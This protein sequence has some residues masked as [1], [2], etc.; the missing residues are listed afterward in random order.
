[1]R[2]KLKSL[3]HRFYPEKIFHAPEWIVLGVNNICNLHCKMCDVGLKINDTNFAVNLTG[4]KPINMP[5]ELIKRLIDQ[6]YQYYPK[7]KLGYAF[8]E[9]LIYPHLMESLTYANDKKLFTSITTNALN[10][11]HKA[12]DLVKAGLNDLYIS[13]DGPEEIHNYIRGHKNSFNRAVEGIEALSEY[14]N[15]PKISVFCVITEWNIGHLREFVESI[16][17]LP[18]TQVGF[19][20]TNFTTNSMADAH[21]ELLMGDYPATYSNTDEID[22]DKMN[23]DILFDEI[24]VL[25]NLSYPFEITFSPQIET[26]EDLQKFYH[27]PE[28]LIGKVCNDVFRN[29]MVKSDG[30]VIPAH[31]RCYNLKIGNLYNETLKDIWNSSEISKFRSRLMEHGGL[32]PACSRC[33]SA[34]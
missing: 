27:Q 10:L 32:F 7:V 9:P 21:N 29:I 16:K 11:K 5:L 20:H 22:L 6:A 18:L 28:V 13:L 1:M 14:S 4:T 2:N 26:R 25:K 3:N 31:G 34:F 12:D 33:C 23:M 24:S 19:M 8:T 15:K 30:S 17:H